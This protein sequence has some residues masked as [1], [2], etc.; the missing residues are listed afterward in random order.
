ME[1]LDLPFG[2]YEDHIDKVESKITE[3]L[4]DQ[5]GSA[6][7]ANEMFRIFSQYNALLVRP[8]IRGAI[9]EYQT[10]LIQKVKEDTE[11]LHDKFKGGYQNSGVALAMR[12]R[13]IPPV[14]GQVMWTKQVTFSPW[15]FKPINTKNYL[16]KFPLE[17]KVW[18]ECKSM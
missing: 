11:Y 5:L 8:R 15:F 9:R 1:C 6:R 3:R 4:R 12:Q 18:I 16:K 10:Q 13:D 17:S 2:S 7:N 14:A